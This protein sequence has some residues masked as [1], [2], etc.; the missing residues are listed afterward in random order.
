[1][2]SENSKIFSGKVLKKLS[3][4][5]I[6]L[7]LVNF[8]IFNWNDVSW[9][10]NYR[11]ISGAVSDFSGKI[12]EK[13]SGFFAKI[14]NKISGIG[15][16]GQ[17]ENIDYSNKGTALEIPKIG[18]SAPLIVAT[19]SNEKDLEAKLNRGVVLFPKSVLPGQSGQ[20]IIL[21]HSAPQ[22]WPKMKYDWVFSRLN[23][24]E[25][26]DEINSILK[27]KNTLIM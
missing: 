1:M 13:I 14:D 19:S 24:L 20:T 22:N 15:Q 27:I 8:L 7:F 18:V 12:S 5:F 4:T 26:K 10:F 17:L 6:L 9:I 2:N 23:E 11:L 3:K 16:I 21:G 25:K